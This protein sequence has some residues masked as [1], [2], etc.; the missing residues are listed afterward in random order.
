MAQRVVVHIGLMK[1]GTTFIQGRLGANRA[2]LMEQG[3]LYPGPSWRR[4]VNAVQ[5]LMGHAG[6]TSGS[7]DSLTQEINA[8]PGTAVIS[9]E[10]LAMAWQR[11]IGILA[12]SF[13][14]AELRIVVGARDLG[15]TVPA[16]W[17]EAVK[18]RSVRT[19]A[20]YVESIREQGEAGKRF[21][22]QQHAGHI[23]GRWAER[24]GAGQ[25]YVVTVP[26]PD[27]PGGLLWDRFCEAATIASEGS[28]DEAPRSNESLGVASTLVLRRLNLMT[29]DLSVKDYKRRVKA[30]G[31]HLMPDHRSAEESIG[32]V[33]PPWL[34][35]RADGI[36]DELATSGVRVVGDLAELTPRDVAGADPDAVDPAAQL[37]AALAALEATL[38]RTGRITR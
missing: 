16:M 5:D 13:G 11:G 20:E 24:V 26:P 34:L 1:S 21:W 3:V 25:V 36:R 2:R 14:D 22:R 8:H 38:R 9:M 37:D 23:A 30:L 32:F 18:N 7:W 12:D 19:F 28:W 10:Y 4:H 33:V 17:Q 35:E 15:R 29:E 27:A 31:K 6:H